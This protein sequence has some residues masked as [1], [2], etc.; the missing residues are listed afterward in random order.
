MPFWL[1]LYLPLAL[2]LCLLL[3]AY[4]WLEDRRDRE[5]LIQDQEARLA[6]AELQLGGRFDDL[7]SD[8]RFLAATPA[9]QTAAASAQPAALDQAATLLATLMRAKPQYAQLQLLDERGAEL[10]HLRNAGPHVERLPPS[11]LQRLAGSDSFE[12]ARL[13]QAGQVY[14]SRFDLSVSHGQIELPHRPSLR[15]STP[16]VRDHRSLVLLADVRGDELLRSLGRALDAPGVEGMLLDRQGYWIYHPDARLRWGFQSS[17]GQSMARLHPQAWR[18]MQASNGAIEQADGLFVYR[19]VHP[20]RG[21]A[22]LSGPLIDTGLWLAVRVT[23]QVLGGGAYETLLPL[24]W[25]LQ[26]LALAGSLAAGRLRRLEAEAR[27][28]EQRTRRATEREAH[29]R[30]RMREQLY[31]TSLRMQS[32]PTAEAFAQTVLSELALNLGAVAGAF[33][34]V[35]D[36]WLR[37]LAGFGLPEPALLRQFRIGEGLLGRALLDRRELQLDALPAGYLDVCSGLGRSSPARLLIVPF[38]IRDERL[39]AIE[40]GLPAPL[41]GAQGQLL[42]QLVPLLSLHLGNYLRRAEPA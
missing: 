31:Q 39:G 18:A 15:L 27:E 11:R 9:L 24:F 40:L 5:R 8:L 28:T 19:R 23:P 4:G 33:Y 2:L 29:E 26:G 22:Q 17:E 16:M 20:F 34:H 21:I 14:V 38:W 13:L 35:E 6:R 41:D 42:R 7:I 37:P 1:R 12:R 36:D 32:A 10:L 30:E 3:G 25:M